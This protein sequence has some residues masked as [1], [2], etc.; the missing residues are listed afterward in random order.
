MSSPAAK[1]AAAALSTH[2]MGTYGRQDVVFE[3][4]EGAWIT[5]TTGER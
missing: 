3:T 5:S 4:G 2:V 1:T